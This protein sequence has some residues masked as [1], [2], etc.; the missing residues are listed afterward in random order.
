M[1]VF[2]DFRSKTN[3]KDTI[4]MGNRNND[5]KK[6]NLFCSNTILFLISVFLITEAHNLIR[7]KFRI[8]EKY[9]IN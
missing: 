4:S 5:L 8:V 9:F 7:R 2:D 1:L 3:C 6:N